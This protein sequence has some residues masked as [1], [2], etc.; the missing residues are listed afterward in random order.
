[1]KCQCCNKESS[2]L[3][4]VMACPNCQTEIVNKPMR[5]A[6]TSG[7]LML[8]IFAAAVVLFVTFVIAPLANKG[9]YDAQYYRG[10]QNNHPLERAP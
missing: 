1:M 2:A 10:N 3:Y 4:G 9:T 8:I 7:A 5:G 6:S